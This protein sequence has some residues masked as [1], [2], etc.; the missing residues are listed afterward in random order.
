MNS[1]L[2][3]NL[4]VPCTYLPVDQA[5]VIPKDKDNTSGTKKDLGVYEPSILTFF[6]TSLQHYLNDKNSKMNIMKDQKL[7][8]SREKIL[9]NKRQLVEV[10]AQGRKKKKQHKDNYGRRN[11][12]ARKP[13]PS[14]ASSTR[15]WKWRTLKSTSFTPKQKNAFQNSPSVSNH[16]KKQIRYLQP[17]IQHIYNKL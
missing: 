15:R 14:S 7:S 2:L 4:L 12:L 6:Q 10:Y 5:I 13:D 17:E 16:R 9:S 8:K 1:V 3:C 11:R